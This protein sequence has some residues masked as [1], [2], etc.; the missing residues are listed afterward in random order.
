MSEHQ[1][2]AATITP[3]GVDSTIGS[4]TK[5]AGLPRRRFLQSTAIGAGAAALAFKAA[6]VALAAEDTTGQV[7]LDAVLIT[8]V[9]APPG[10]SGGT[11]WE[12][13]KNRTNTYKLS[14]TLQQGISLRSDTTGTTS[15]GIDKSKFT[16][17]DSM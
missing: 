12:Y 6:D 2:E 7:T 13:T 1:K 17:G 5:S 9:G 8:Y 3:Q 14:L 16:V 4:P 15:T 11:M 10:C